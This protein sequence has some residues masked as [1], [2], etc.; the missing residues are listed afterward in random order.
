MRT[1]FRVAAGLAVGLLLAGC[2][3]APAGDNGGDST[4]I[5]YSNSVSGGRGDW[6]VGQA[7]K[8]GFTV[9]YV[10]LG[11]VDIQNRLIAEKGNPVADVMFGPT[12]VPCETLVA[13]DALQP[14]EPAWAP[15]VDRQKASPAGD[16]WPVVREPIM[17]VYDTADYPNGGAPTDWPDLWEKP[18][19]HDKYETSTNLAA[20]TTSMVIAS[21]FARYSDPSGHLGV[22]DAGW[23]AI[24]SFYKYGSPSVDGLD[25]YARMADG[26][27]TA[28]Q[29]F[30]AGKTSR[31]KEYGVSTEAAHPATG[32]PI[33]YQQVAVVKNAPHAE[34]AKRFV[35]WLGS[36]EVQAD[37]S[38]RYFTAPTN[39]DAIPGADKDAVSYTNSFREQDIDWAFVAKNLDGWIEEIQLKYLVQ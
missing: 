20:G 11:A 12:T 36:A 23:R 1:K 35:D 7:A 16:F 38:H 3:G 33:V 14:Y 19:F 25:L 24:A 39:T 31:E 10:D 21:I 18:Q 34:L 13:A 30:L 27:V 4:L 32:V 15:L 9:E 26:Q 29:M 2:S 8:A 37:W 28:G 6:L 17:L 22:S 5:V